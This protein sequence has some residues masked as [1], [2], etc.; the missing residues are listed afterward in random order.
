ME[1]KQTTEIT[2]PIE[3]LAANGGSGGDEQQNERPKIGEG[4]GTTAALSD[5]GNGPLFPV[6]VD[7]SAM[8]GKMCLNT[9]YSLRRQLF[10]S[11]G[12]L[13][14]VALMFVVLIAIITT[15]LAGNQVKYTS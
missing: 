2:A 12:T 8:V 6:K 4:S 3:S 13:S 10:L 15:S 7:G 9:N 14:A 11:F 5:T 1:S